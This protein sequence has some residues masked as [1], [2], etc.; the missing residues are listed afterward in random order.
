[1][2][3]LTG[4]PNLE[5]IAEAYSIPYLHFGRAS[6]A[7]AVIGEFLAGDRTVLLEVE[8]DPDATV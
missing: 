1:M 6:E 4:S 3:D 8:I 2:V 7:E 5:K